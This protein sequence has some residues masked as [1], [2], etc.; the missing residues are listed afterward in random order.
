MYYNNYHLAIVLA[1]HRHYI[2]LGNTCGNEILYTIVH[3]HLPWK[4][5]HGI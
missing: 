4:I 2:M 1:I 5:A 3:T